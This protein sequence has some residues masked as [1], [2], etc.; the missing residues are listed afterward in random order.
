MERNIT[1]FLQK[2][3]IVWKFHYIIDKKYYFN[4]KMYNYALFLIIVSILVFLFGLLF[5]SGVSYKYE[6]NRWIKGIMI[7]ILVVLGM[8]MLLF[9]FVIIYGYN[10]SRKYISSKNNYNSWDVKDLTPTDN[11]NRIGMILGDKFNNSAKA[12][13]NLFRSK[14]E[15]AM[16]KVKDAKERVKVSGEKVTTLERTDILRM[17]GEVPVLRRDERKQAEK[18]LEKAN[19]EWEQALEDLRLKEEYLD[20]LK[21][22]R[23]EDPADPIVTDNIDNDLFT[24]PDSKKSLIGSGK[25]LYRRIFPKKPSKDSFNPSPY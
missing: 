18:D 12:F 1:V 22:T 5:V 16:N 4:L 25:D 17:T 11:E 7:S 3:I 14:L 20:K 19:T 15:K 24:S 2:K 13:K 6:E 10:T 23:D 9:G 8:L 21:S